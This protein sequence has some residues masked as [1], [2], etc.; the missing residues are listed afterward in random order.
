MLRMNQFIRSLMDDW[1]SAALAY[2]RKA[3]NISQMLINALQQ[4]NNQ[5][6]LETEIG[7]LGI[8][9]F[10]YFTFVNFTFA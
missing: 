9:N 10:T 5:Y 7:N 8:K 6:E 1:R 2:S 4:I 3:F